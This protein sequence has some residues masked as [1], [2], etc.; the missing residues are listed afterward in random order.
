MTTNRSAPPGSVVPQ[1]AYADVREA[2]AWLARAFGLSP[3]L[4]IGD[5][6]VQLTIG[7]GSVVAIERRDDG[8]GE[9]SSVLV[10]V[11]GVAAHHAR[12]LA[13]GATIITAPASFPYGERQYT[14]EDL[15]GHR[16][17]FTESVADVDPADWG[18]EPG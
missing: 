11:D 7:D 3:R 9:R 13:A 18:G 12:A 6:R 14:A 4:Y 17:T 16:W 1:L 5:H 10:R 8:S 2:A 15:A